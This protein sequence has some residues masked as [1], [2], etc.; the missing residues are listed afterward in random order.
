M[1]KELLKSLVES[2]EFENDD[3]D[4]R[5]TKARSYQEAIPIIK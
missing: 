2:E 5:A 4:D 3:L 1:K